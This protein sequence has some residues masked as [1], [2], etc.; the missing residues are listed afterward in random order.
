DERRGARE[1]RRRDDRPHLARPHTARR[2]PERLDDR[3]HPPPHRRRGRGRPERAGLDRRNSRGDP[4][5]ERGTSDHRG[6][7]SA[8]G[9]D[10]PG[11]EL[12]PVDHSDRRAG[13]RRAPARA[14]ASRCPPEGP[15]F[16]GAGRGRGRRRGRAP[17]AG[18]TRRT[19][20]DTDII[21]ENE[22][23]KRRSERGPRAVEPG[24]APDRWTAAERTP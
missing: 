6:E 16:R 21:K 11:G 12:S 19:L 10:G 15:Q 3:Y 20:T 24:R 7:R 13:P 2:G 8:L 5:R 17:R 18:G 23:G 4:P 22:D 9:P 1:A 14:R